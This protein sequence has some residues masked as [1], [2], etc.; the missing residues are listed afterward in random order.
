[1]YRFFVRR[2]SYN[3]LVLVIVVI[4]VFIIGRMIPGDSFLVA[5]QGGQS[6]VDAAEAVKLLE[7]QY[8]LDLPMYQQF[9]FWFGNF[10]TGDWGVS[11]GTGEDVLE[12]F[13]ARSRVT[14]DL[15]IV[16][17][18]WTFAIG[19]PCGIAS[20]L[21]RNTR[22]DAVITTGALMSLAIPNFWFAIVLIYLFAVLLPIFPPF[23]YVPFAK[24]PFGNFMSLMLPGFVLGTGA[25][26]ALVRY[27]RS[28]LLEVLG[29]DYIRTARSKG[30]GESKVIGVH[31]MKPALIP[32]VTIIGFIWIALLTGTFLIE[33]V[34][35]LPGLGR[36]AVQSIFQRDF[37]VVMAVLV[38][39][40]VVILAFN[41]FVDILYGYLDPRVRVE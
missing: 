7:A 22:V 17:N 28:S 4:M 18:F 39:N 8:G 14:F 36:M 29:Q 6:G 16:A 12:M 27:I 38:M 41:F 15:F 2:L 19:V 31:A 3:L 34:F 10:V 37:P 23:G 32:V 30:L 13:K 24:D 21:K 35:A 9:F 26:G 25:A 20:A 40:S 33:V 1:M 11:I 5:L